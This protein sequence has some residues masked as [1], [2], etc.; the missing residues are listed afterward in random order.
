MSGLVDLD[1]D[2]DLDPSRDLGLLFRPT[3]GV[4]TDKLTALARSVL[5]VALTA[6][7]KE[8]ALHS[9]NVYKTFLTFWEDSFICKIPCW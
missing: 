8:K 5:P 9:K 4:E 1:L 2:R 6:A 7:I 3:E